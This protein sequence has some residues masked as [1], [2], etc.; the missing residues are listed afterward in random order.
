MTNCYKH[1]DIMTE[2]AIR[3]DFLFPNAKSGHGV[4]WK[5]SPL[6]IFDSIWYTEFRQQIL[7]S[8]DP[9]VILFYCEASNTNDYG[10]IDINEQHIPVTPVPAALNWVVKG[11][12]ADS[13]MVWYDQYEFTEDNLWYGP[14]DP[15]WSETDI[16]RRAPGAAIW[17]VSKLSEIE[18]LVVPTDHITLVNTG[19]VHRIELGPANRWCVSIR[20]PFN[21]TD[22]W[23]SYCD[24]TRKYTYGDIK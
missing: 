2:S 23:E 21:A 24:L 12:G 13:Y 11:S 7:F 9:T 8:G 22:N 10:H 19:I 15:T 16:Q 18:R 14:S 3:G 17:R 1:L 20:L 5:Y 6:D 4:H